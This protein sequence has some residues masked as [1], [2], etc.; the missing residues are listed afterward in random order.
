MPRLVPSPKQPLRTVASTIA[1]MAE[2]IVLR[3]IIQK[4]YILYM[5]A[6]S[7]KSL[8]PHSSETATEKHSRQTI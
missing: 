8:V 7:Q 2:N 6:R 5:T 3:F 1:V 4:S